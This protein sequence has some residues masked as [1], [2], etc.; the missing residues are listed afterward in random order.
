[1]RRMRSRICTWEKVFLL[2]QEKKPL[3]RRTFRRQRKIDAAF[4]LSHEREKERERDEARLLRGFVPCPS[5][6]RI[7]MRPRLFVPRT[8]TPRRP[9]SFLPHPRSRFN[10]LTNQVST[11]VFRDL[12]TLPLPTRF[13]SSAFIEIPISIRPRIST[14]PQTPGT[15]PQTTQKK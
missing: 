8:S 2:L 10:L 7:I 13:L 11:P 5:E 3:L 12:D 9:A 6:I 15:P 4:D 14:T 1:L